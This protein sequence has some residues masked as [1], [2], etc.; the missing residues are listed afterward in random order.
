MTDR[1]ERTRQRRANK[2]QQEREAHRQRGGEYDRRHQE[3]VDETPERH[4]SRICDYSNG[5]RTNVFAG[6]MHVN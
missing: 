3:P 4:E 1:N 6:N 5:D 2:S